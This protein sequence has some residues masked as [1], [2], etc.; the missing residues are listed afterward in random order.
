MTGAFDFLIFFSLLFSALLS[1]LCRSAAAAAA[2]AA[3]FA[4]SC[5]RLRRS[6]LSV[7]FLSP[8]TSE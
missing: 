2:A 7:L 6:P 8:S 5:S 3:A 4:F 1:L